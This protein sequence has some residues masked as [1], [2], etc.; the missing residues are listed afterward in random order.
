M[1]FSKLSSHL[2]RYKVALAVFAVTF[3]ASSTSFGVVP[4]SAINP[5]CSFA[6]NIELEEYGDGLAIE[7][8]SV[9]GDKI[10]PLEMVHAALKIYPATINLW[11]E[12]SK[13]DP[14]FLVA[15]IAE[16]YSNFVL[17]L[18]KNHVN[19]VAIDLGYGIDPQNLP[20]NKSG[21]LMAAFL[22]EAKD[23]LIPGDAYNLPL[24]DKSVNV[25]VSHLLVNNIDDVND[26]LEILKEA[27]RVTK[28]GGEIKIFG[29]D[30]FDRDI[31]L[32]LLDADGRYQ[33]SSFKFEP[34]LTNSIHVPP[35]LQ[36]K[37]T[38]WYLLKINLK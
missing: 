25:Y 36:R 9:T 11:S 1:N 30:E 24:I 4:K 37:V 10:Y 27:L 2:N 31:I 33:S 29:F 16:G 8:V 22:V 12:A 15:S 19:A 32:N 3:F 5:N 35:R 34:T 13:A 23:F 28:D 20:K 21:E 14:N 18:N 17:N 7:G 26:R 6:F 38:G